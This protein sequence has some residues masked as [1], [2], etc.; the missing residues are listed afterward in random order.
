MAERSGA[1]KEGQLDKKTK[2]IENDYKKIT[3]YPLND[4]KINQIKQTVNVA[5]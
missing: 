4:V 2:E 1:P 5:P 3:Y